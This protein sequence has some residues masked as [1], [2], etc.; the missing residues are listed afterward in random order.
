MHNGTPPKVFYKEKKRICFGPP[1]PDA[2]IL[3]LEHTYCAELDNF[4]IIAA[5]A[6]LAEEGDFSRAAQLFSVQTECTLEQAKEFV[7]KSVGDTPAAERVPPNAT[8][9]LHTSKKT[10][11]IMGLYSPLWYIAFMLV[12]AAL[13]FYFFVYR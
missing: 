10:Q 2:Q 7:A 9:I 5:A 1:P 12:A 6:F 11:R 3:D 4:Q 13:V 8:R